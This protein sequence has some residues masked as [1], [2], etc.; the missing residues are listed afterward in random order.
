MSESGV[1]DELCE[2]IKTV[3]SEHYH[4]TDIAEAL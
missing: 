4:L 3:D 2:L 1:A